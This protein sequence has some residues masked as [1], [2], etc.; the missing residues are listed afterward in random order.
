MNFICDELV[1]HWNDKENEVILDKSSGINF[2]HEYYIL[3]KKNSKMEEEISKL[4][5]ENKE[6]KRIN[7][8]L[9]THLTILINDI[10]I[11]K[12]VKLDLNDYTGFEA[13]NASE[14]SMK[15]FF[16]LLVICEKMKYS[17]IEEIWKIEA[18]VLFKEVKNTDL[19]FYEWPS[20]I[21]KSLENEYSII[22]KKKSIFNQNTSIFGKMKYL[23]TKLRNIWFDSSLNFYNKFKVYA[24]FSKKKDI[25]SSLESKQINDQKK[26]NGIIA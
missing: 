1:D 7:K 11:M 25:N 15:E 13:G 18:N 9:N 24:N 3:K 22:Q 17:N 16:F 21:K 4:I 23:I 2:E 8:N 6:Y 10:D 5:N 20:F 19:P 26:I 12:N 14:E